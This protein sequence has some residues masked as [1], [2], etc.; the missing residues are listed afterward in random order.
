MF[1]PAMSPE[2]RA[3]AK[4]WG[5]SDDEIDGEP[6]TVWPDNAKSV[7]LL[8][9][10]STQWRVGGMGAATGLDYSA[11]PEIWRRLK[12]PPAQRDELFADLQLM[13]RAALKAM[14]TKED[15]G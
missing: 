13:E 7:D 1:A 10:M 15:D 6:I 4:A 5:F 3:S 2:K 8:I 12:V 9:A 14:H 11:L